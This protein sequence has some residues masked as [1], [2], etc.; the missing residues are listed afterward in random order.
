MPRL[1]GN[2][3]VT[4]TWGSNLNRGAGQSKDTVCPDFEAALELFHKQEN[5]RRKRKY[6]FLNSSKN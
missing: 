6:V 3:I 4:R 1:V 2:W 5:R